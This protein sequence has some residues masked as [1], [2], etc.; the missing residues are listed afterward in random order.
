MAEFIRFL[1]TGGCSTALDFIL[2]M[3][4]IQHLPVFIS[5][6]ISMTAA[7]VFSYIANKIFTFRNKSKPDG[8][9]M[10]RFYT[11]FAVNFFVN[12]MTN[13]VLYDITADRLLSY[14][15]AVL[16]GMCVNYAGQKKY[17]F[18]DSDRKRQTSDKRDD[19]TGI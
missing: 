4:F 1:L 17:V 15:A 7:S 5:K 14:T 2:Y 9:C 3:F 16:A 6:S 13:S 8:K 10:I 18:K 12:T 11:V 19:N